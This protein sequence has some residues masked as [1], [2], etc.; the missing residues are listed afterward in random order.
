MASVSSESPVITDSPIPKINQSV[1]HVSIPKESPISVKKMA[2]SEDIVQVCFDP[3]VIDKK[4]LPN[5][6][7]EV[8]AYLAKY[9]VHWYAIGIYLKVPHEWLNEIE[10][11]YPQNVTRQLSA[12]IDKWMNNSNNCTWKAL[13]N[14]VK[15]FKRQASDVS[16]NTGITLPASKLVIRIENPQEVRPLEFLKEKKKL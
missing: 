5:N 2:T 1:D 13:I 15:K 9:S 3:A 6:F 10:Y 11:N 12:M 4:I 14:A 8:Y 7:P 16:N